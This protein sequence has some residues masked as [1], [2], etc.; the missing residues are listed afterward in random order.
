MDQ[1]EN[2][3]DHLAPV[4][5]TWAKKP[6]VNQP[7][8]VVVSKHKNKIEKMAMQPDYLQIKWQK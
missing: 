7:T 3:A 1:L 5:I 2:Q 4:D 6:W 8:A